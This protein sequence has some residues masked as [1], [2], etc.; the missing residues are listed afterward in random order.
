MAATHQSLYQ[1][2]AIFAGGLA[3]GAGAFALSR[4][5]FAPAHK[6]TKAI[7]RKL[8][9][10][11]NAAT[12]KAKAAAI[13]PAANDDKAAASPAPVAPASNN[14]KQAK[15][16]LDAAAAALEAAPGRVDPPL[17]QV[18][19]A[20]DQ[21]GPGPVQPAKPQAEGNVAPSGP[22]ATAGG[23]KL[24]GLVNEQPKLD[25]EPE[26]SPLNR[27]SHLD[28][29]ADLSLVSGPSADEL[30]KHAAAQAWLTGIPSPNTTSTGVIDAIAYANSTAV[31]SYESEANGG[32][33]AHS[34]AQAAE[35]LDKG[36]TQG[37]PKVFK[38]QTR[39]G[40]GN[41][42][43]GYLSGA[44]KGSS[45]S[46][47][48]RVVTALTNAAGFVA[49]A[50][51]LAALDDVATDA[52]KIV[53]Q[54]SA[55]SQ[56]TDDDLAIKNDY[57]AVLAATAA[58]GDA[59]EVVFSSTR[60][61][62]VDSAQYAYQSA[63]NVVH[64]FDGAFAGRE[65]GLLSVPQKGA[66]VAAPE[67]FHYTG[68]AKATAVL[69]VPNGS[70]S[71]SARAVLVTLPPAVRHNIGVLSVKVVRP[72]SD[73]EL[74]KAIPETVQSLHVLE[75][76]PSGSTSG[77]VYEDVMGS[78]FSDAFLGAGSAP[79]NV[80]SVALE[81]GQNLVAAEW[82]ELLKTVAASPAAP[83]KLGDVFDAATQ[84]PDLLA[85]SGASLASG[86]VRSD[87]ILTGRPESASDA[88]IEL[89]GD[90]NSSKVLVVSDP[91][92]TLKSLAPF[93]SLVRG[94]T[95]IVNVPGWDAAELESKLRAE[96]KKVLADKG[97]RLLL[98]DAAAVVEQLN[99][100]TAN[101]RGG[102]A[103]AGDDVVPK[104]IAAAV[105]LVA[106]LRTQL[107]LGGDALAAFVTRIL[108][109]APVG[110]DGVAGLVQA[111]E[112]A[113]ER[114]AFSNAEWANAEPLEGESA[115]APRPTH[116][117]YN[118]FTRS[119]D[120]A[121]AG[122][123]V[124]PSRNTWALPAWQQLFSEAYETDTSAIRPDLPEKTWVIEV[125]ENRRLTPVDYDRNVFH[126]ELSTKGT[127][128]RYEVG[129]AL[130]VHGWN[131]DDEVADFIRWA[132]FDADEV[133]SVPSLAKPAKFETRTVFQV[134]QQN[135]D[136][137]GKPPK[138]FYE[139]LSKIA[140]NRDEARW[141]RFISSAEG[142]ATFKKYSEVETLTYADVLRM[143]PSARLPLDLLLTEVEPIKP[144]HYSIASAQAAVG[145]SVHLL[146]VTVD[147]KTPSG[148]PRYGQCTRYLSKLKPGAKVTVSLKPS[149]MKLPP[150]DSQPI[151]MAGLG[152]GAAPFRAFIQARAVKRAQ[153]ID[154][155]PLVY[156]FGSRYRSAEYLYGEELE[157]YLQD[158]VLS[159]VGLAF[160]RDTSKKVYIQ[161]K[162]QQDGEMLT[163][164]LAPEIEA[165]KKL[166]GSAEVAIRDGALDDHVDEGKKGY[167]FVCGPTWPVPDI[168]EAIV[169]AFV[170]RGWTQERAEQRI[171]ELKEEEMDFG[172]VLMAL[173][174][175]DDADDG[176]ENEDLTIATISGR[177]WWC[178][179]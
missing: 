105:L 40:A 175:V 159:H 148:S 39:S 139:A 167:F 78:L 149:V 110:V 162:I 80:F 48:T 2:A 50:P 137:F 95:V 112:A 84:Q 11:A 115:S 158:G 144:R 142:S 17:A 71:Q 10:A 31:F 134:L 5:A 28:T 113:V 72:W 100:K 169:S 168:H 165:L 145:E 174:V 156:Y 178:R 152:T 42:I 136:I 9:D 74:R 103:K 38:M 53:L 12:N 98:V 83:V 82:F 150:I 127:D 141:L 36:W 63:K 22:D 92:V 47:P 154:V 155:G 146:V 163:N 176:D 43:V 114:F 6:P 52:G 121:L 118:G 89:V 26:P 46:G 1:S 93:Q 30:A 4:N 81:A 116:I 122:V 143:F 55:A 59:F 164:Y 79:R 129:E 119:A 130:G 32:F 172:G 157:A 170:E 161:H 54:V 14:D 13:A 8:S 166:G 76:I 151:I 128:L 27:V 126:M 29:R 171:E 138:R 66:A 16:T 60:Q 124:A 24:K 125:T 177:A 91:A 179:R 64:V 133:V 35:A 44:K 23:Q 25:A 49:M 65:V 101:A 19:D 123:E 62:A 68:P 33:G 97:A 135:L 77:L 85:L 147:W 67:H 73:A 3:I 56:S 102:K 20:V 34:E 140:T 106:F 117:R 120:A 94:G 87:L 58:L 57:A 173:S 131:D 90:D 96:D 109:T 37:R 18:L 69:V 41:A 15:E 75:E 99:T 88:P 132:G 61:E 70:H 7:K 108:G 45:S 104:E 160:S 153:G 107:D 111:T 21:K 86:L 51:T